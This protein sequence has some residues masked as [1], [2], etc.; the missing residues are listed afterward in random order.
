M[1]PID[2]VRAGAE[3][4]DWFPLWRNLLRWAVPVFLGF[5]LVYDAIP[6]TWKTIAALFGGE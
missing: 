2:E 6:S 4:V 3:G 5:V 1:D